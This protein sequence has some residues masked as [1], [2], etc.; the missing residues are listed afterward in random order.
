MSDCIVA[1]A[2]AV[3]IIQDNDRYVGRLWHGLTVDGE[4]VA[5]CA[6]P[7]TESYSSR[8]EVSAV[9]QAVAAQR[10]FK[11]AEIIAR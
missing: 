4:F 1:D 5:L 11:L 7:L 6:L 2:A 9:L 8:A 10:G 3:E